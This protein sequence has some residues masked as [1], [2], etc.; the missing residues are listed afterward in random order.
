MLGGLCSVPAGMLC[1]AFGIKRVLILG[2]SRSAAGGRHVSH[3]R[4][5]SFVGALHRPW[6]DVR[7]QQHGR[8]ELPAERRSSGRHGH[9]LGGIFSEQYAW[10]RR[11]E[12]AGRTRSRQPGIRAPRTSGL[13]HRRGYRRYGPRYAAQP[14]TPRKLRQVG[15]PFSRR[16]YRPVPSPGSPPACWRFGIC[17]PAIGVR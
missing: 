16:L 12:S 14:S 15:H 6:N 11:G 1:D 8:A 4:P 5:L 3:G 7:I 2:Q 9:G 17:P 10:R 13:R